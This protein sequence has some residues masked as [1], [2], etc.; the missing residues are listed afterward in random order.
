MLSPK[1]LKELADRTLA[2]E[3]I[4]EAERRQREVAAS[5][6]RA[7]EQEITDKILL[8]KAVKST[9]WQIENAARNGKFCANVYAVPV[10]ELINPYVYLSHPCK[11]MSGK[12]FDEFI[13]L[14]FQVRIVHI[15]DKSC[16]DVPSDTYYIQVSW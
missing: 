3:K 12:V 6:V 7:R 9:G 8:D 14:G 2:H 13:K 4:E 15:L 16:Q 1:E 5:L 10:D 11:G